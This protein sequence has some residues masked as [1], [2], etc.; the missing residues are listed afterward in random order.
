MEKKLLLALGLLLGSQALSAQKMLILE[1]ANS[2]R[3]TKYYVGSPLNYR[4][5][6]PEHY[7]YKV[8]LDDVRVETNTAVL[9]AV[10]VRIEDIAYLKVRKKPVWR[11]VGGSLVTFGA[12]LTFATT[13]ALLYRDYEYA[14]LYGA[15]VGSFGVG[16][17]LTSP[18]KLKMGERHRL[19]P[20]EI[21]F[22][23]EN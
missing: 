3:T 21:A 22:P 7:W 11:I 16:L 12:S 8:T 23:T 15:A 13:I 19:R 4:A 1:R 6:G 17:W 18:R 2:P 9:D 20:V 5:K 10:P 14:P